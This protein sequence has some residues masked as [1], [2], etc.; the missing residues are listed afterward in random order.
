MDLVHGTLRF[1]LATGAGWV[2]WLLVLLIVFMV[3]ASLITTPSLKVELPRGGVNVK[4]V[5]NEP[6]VVV[7]ITRTGDIQLKDHPIQLAGLFQELQKE[8]KTKPSANLLIVADRKAYHENVVRV[9]G[10]AK[11]IGFPKLGIAMT[12]DPN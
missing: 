2:M 8:H 10:L 1:M 7:V 3:T 5:S 11:N 12:P 6:N 4:N 9:M